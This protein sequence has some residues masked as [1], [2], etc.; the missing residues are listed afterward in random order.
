MKFIKVCWVFT[1]V[2]LTLCLHSV[3]HAEKNTGSIQKIEGTIY[4]PEQEPKEIIPE[5]TEIEPQIIED[6]TEYKL[7]VKAQDRLPVFF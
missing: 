7:L 5:L 1:A 4:I 2:V 6:I 3:T